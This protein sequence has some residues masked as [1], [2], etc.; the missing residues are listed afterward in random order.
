VIEDVEELSAELQ[1][2]ALADLRGLEQRE[3]PVG[4]AGAD[5]AIARSI[6]NRSICGSG[7]GA[8]VEVLRDSLGGASLGVECAAKGSVYVGTDRIAA[9]A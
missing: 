5:E 1:A 3:I 2:G 4:E 6:A 7:E 9:V 8:G